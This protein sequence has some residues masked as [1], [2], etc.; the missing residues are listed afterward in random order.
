MEEQ[1]LAQQCKQGD[2]KARKQLYELYGGRMLGICLRYVGNKETAED[3]MHD[4][5][6]R[7]FESFDK[8]TWRGKGSLCAWMDKVMVNIA[9][10]YLRKNDIISQAI[11]LDNAPEAYETPEITSMEVIPCNVLMDFIT[12]LPA[13]Y[14]TVFNLY[15]FEKKSHKEIS[16]ILGINEKSSASQLA[17]A[18]ASLAN[19]IR[20]WMKNNL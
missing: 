6:L 15:I 18:K 16:Q 3:L 5:F 19:Q 2:V 8:F 7:I 4:G 10:Q 12:H 17:R 14:R 9:L 1:E 13:G 11:S 20:T